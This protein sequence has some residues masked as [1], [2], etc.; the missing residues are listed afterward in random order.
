MRYQ[1][2]FRTLNGRDATAEQTLKFERLVTTLETTPGD[3]LL[4]VLVAL[5]HY[6]TLYSEIP[7][8][9]KTAAES[10]ATSAAQVAQ[11]ELTHAVALLIPT[12]KKAV[13][14]SASN[15]VR[16]ISLGQS[17]IELWLATLVLGVMFA[18]GWFYGSG[19]LSSVQHG[20][21]KMV[22]FWRLTG[23][24]LGAGFAVPATLIFAAFAR[25]D[26]WSMYASIAAATLLPALLFLRVLGLF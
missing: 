2:V 6:E 5:D 26:H 4:S 14:D 20:S 16:R 24:G 1:D 15:T 25:D 23:A 7:G 22:E 19:L 17:C 10:A 3:A 8:R 12:V 21:V 9:I 13:S 18:L 11:A